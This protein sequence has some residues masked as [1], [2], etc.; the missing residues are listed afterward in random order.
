MNRCDSMR[1]SIGAWLDGELDPVETESVRA[2]LSACPACEQACADWRKIHATLKE[3]LS[4]E[5]AGVD[6]PSFWHAVQGRIG[7]RRGWPATI[8]D[9]W[10]GL[11]LPLRSAW[12]VPAIILLLLSFVSVDS[13]WPGWRS[14]GARSS[15]AVVDSIDAHGRNVGLWRED[16]TKTT[17]IWLYEDQEGEHEAAEETPKSGPAF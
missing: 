1:A 11:F 2:H 7:H 16:E 15:F 3:M 17:V 13:F 8:R 12:A 6:F 14:G 10:R 5:A 9:R 4:A